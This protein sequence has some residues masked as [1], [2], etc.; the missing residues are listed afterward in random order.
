ML[1]I[2]IHDNNFKNCA[3]ISVTSFSINTSWEKSLKNSERNCQE[4]IEM[5]TE[6]K[7][8]TMSF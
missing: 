3:F 4:R 5:M 7:E 1:Q 6:D 8:F 2:S